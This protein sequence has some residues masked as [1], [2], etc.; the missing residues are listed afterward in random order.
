[1]RASSK[2]SERA[3]EYEGVERELESVFAR[4]LKS[5]FKRELESRRERELKSI[6]ERA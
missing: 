4:Q 3:R 2:E 6:Y 5:V 1:M